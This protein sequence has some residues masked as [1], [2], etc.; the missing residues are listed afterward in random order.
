M[1]GGVSCKCEGT[2]KDKIPNWKIVHY[3]C[4]HSAFNGY[5]KT[6]SDYSLIRCMKCGHSWRTK[7]EYVNELD[8]ATEE[9][10]FKSI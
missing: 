3:R 6:S 4:N 1:S 9:E 7:A 8:F 5:H 10:R 2:R